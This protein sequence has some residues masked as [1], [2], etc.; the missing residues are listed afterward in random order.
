MT[1]EFTD[2][3]VSIAGDTT[4]D[5]NKSLMLS[6]RKRRRQTRR[7]VVG[8]SSPEIQESDSES[9]TGLDEELAE[10]LTE[11]SVSVSYAH[12]DWSTRLD[13]MSSNLD[14]LVKFVRRGMESL[15]GGS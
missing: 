7:N 14:S 13:K 5:H 11:P 2:M 3:F 6:T 12:E 8:F 9:D 4:R 1:L 15:A 10:H